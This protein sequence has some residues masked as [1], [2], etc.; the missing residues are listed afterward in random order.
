MTDVG[1]LIISVTGITD[2]YPEEAFQTLLLFFIPFLYGLP[3]V[4]PATDN[5]LSSDLG[6]LIRVL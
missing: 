3:I 2:G 6:E 5:S 1:G 4:I